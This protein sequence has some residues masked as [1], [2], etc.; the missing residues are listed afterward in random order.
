MMTVETIIFNTTTWIFF[1]ET[2]FFILQLNGGEEFNNCYCC[3][4]K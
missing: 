1:S 2:C 4:L 3:L